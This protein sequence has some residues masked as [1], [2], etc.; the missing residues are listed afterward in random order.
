MNPS[1]V[2]VYA[3]ASIG[4]VSVGFDVLGLAVEPIDGSLFG[5]VVTAQWSDVDR[6]TFGGRFADALPKDDN[7]VLVC[8]ELFFARSGVTRRPVALHLDKEM[9]IGSGLG[10]SAC[11]V[12]A[13]CYALNELFGRPLNSAQLLALTAE[14]ESAISGARHLDNVAPCLL[15]GLQLCTLS[16]SLPTIAL[17][18]PAHWYWVMAYPGVKLNTADSRRALPQNYSQHDTVVAMQQLASFIAALQAADEALI[19]Q[20]WADVLAEPYRAPLIPN[21]VDVK[22]QLLALGALH[23]GISGSG[24]TLFAVANDAQQAQALAELCQAQFCN[25]H[26]FVK[27]CQASVLGTRAL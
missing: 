7:I 15:G 19:C 1:M 4:N 22:Q 25:E 13:A 18:V 16:D 27:I 10:S 20:H 14:P 3:P 9:P 24:P 5:D 12:V 17:P 6:F 8:R 21:F 11:S 2:K 26:G 23:V